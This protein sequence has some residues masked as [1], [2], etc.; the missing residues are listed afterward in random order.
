MIE[1]LRMQPIGV[2]IAGLNSSQ[3]R[4]FCTPFYPGITVLLKYLDPAIY[5]R[6]IFSL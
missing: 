5:T 4:H 3:F 6:L 2:E 1:W